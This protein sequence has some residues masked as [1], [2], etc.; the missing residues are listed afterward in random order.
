MSFLELKI[1]PPVYLVLS[2]ILAVVITRLHPQGVMSPPFPLWGGIGLVMIGFVSDIPAIL[3]F[4]RAKTTILPTQPQKTS[5]LVTSGLYR[6]TRNPMYLGMVFILW[7]V[8]WYLGHPGNYAVIA[9]FVLVMT[10]FQI[11]P[12]ER[13]LMALFGEEYADYKRRVRR[14]I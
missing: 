12:E 11:I 4:A 14:W 6:I 10:R 3:A 1:P 13:A 5:A 7:G 2:I 8:S 9:L